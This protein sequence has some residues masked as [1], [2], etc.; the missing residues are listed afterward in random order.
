MIYN[1]DISVYLFSLL[2]SQK[3]L[4]DRLRNIE[5]DLNSYAKF[6]SNEKILKDDEDGS[7]GEIS[8]QT[9]K[10]ASSA[11]SLSPTWQNLKMTKRLESAEEAIDKLF[12]LMNDLLAKKK[13]EEVESETKEKTFEENGNITREYTIGSAKGRE[14]GDKLNND[15]SDL[16]ESYKD[17]HEK[18]KGKQSEIEDNFKDM[19]SKFEKLEG[20]VNSIQVNVKDNV[21]NI[22]ANKTSIGENT[23]SVG[24]LENMLK[25][26]D[27]SLKKAMKDLSS[28][29]LQKD[30]PVVM[31]KEQSELNT[32]DNKE[33]MTQDTENL[34][35]QI[36]ANSDN[37]EDLRK[38]I[39]ELSLKVDDKADGSKLAALTDA[40]TSLDKN[41]NDSLNKLGGEVEKLKESIS[42]FDN[43]ELKNVL[44]SMEDLK[45]MA[46][47]IED[48]RR[49]S[50]LKDLADNVD[51]L[52]DL[53][54][55]IDA[56]KQ[57]MAIGDESSKNRDETFKSIID[58][59]T[60]KQESLGD[61]L[62]K[63]RELMNSI[64]NAMKSM[65]EEKGI[66]DANT[67]E[68]DQNVRR[69]CR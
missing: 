49:L 9:K 21:K 27:K 66:K 14:D 17:E 63:L 59:Y 15:L 18:L 26:L 38:Q 34:K 19:L 62:N 40:L 69:F 42:N 12:S 31:K 45:K 56:L 64:E 50:D 60:K 11:E 22:D 10:R 20:D 33:H 28:T 5:N 24:N 55:D 37:L 67:P 48:L 51:S 58:D 53:K 13:E 46:E 30:I 57:S 1:E 44:E 43:S 16:R 6:A 3:A 2:S 8:K 39:K 41:T 36:E 35:K 47:Q 29:N 7:K 54:A 25:E 52:K 61:E 4:D 68:K 32:N 65:E 23:Q